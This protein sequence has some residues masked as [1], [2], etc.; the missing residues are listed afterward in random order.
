MVLP[1]AWHPRN[2]NALIVCDL[3]ADP[4]PLLEL[5]A[6]EL[7]RRLYTRRDELAEGELPVPLK[8]I[9][10]NRCPVVAPLSVLRAEDRLRTGIDVEACQRRAELL[11]Q[12]QAAWTEKLA[13][14]YSEESFAASED[15]EQQL[16]DGFIGDR[17]RRLCE[18][19]RRAE[20]EQLA[21]EQWPFDD[22]RLQEL[23]FRYRARN[24][25]ETLSPSERQQWEAFCRNRL[26]HE[27][28]GA[29]NTLPAFEAAMEACRQEQGGTLPAV[30][31]AWRDYAGELRRRYALDN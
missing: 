28:F 24:F 17:D 9:Q 12:R 19:L 5:S 26:S 6:E 25:P 23:F 1:L 18:Q 29:P 4:A 31:A 27:E 15:P 8:Q 14:A 2:R 30:L 16:Y 11:R 13:L 20:P 3:R 10:V 22:I 7:R 21:R